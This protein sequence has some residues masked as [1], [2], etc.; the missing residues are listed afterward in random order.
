MPDPLYV[1]ARRVLLDALEALREHI[2]ALVLVGAQAVYVHAGEADLAVAPTTTDGDLA[3][4]PARLGPA[5]ILED[6]LARAGFEQEHNVVGIWHTSADVEGTPRVVQVDLL[7]PASLG[8]PGRRGARIPPHGKAVARKVVGLEGAL[9]D[10]DLHLITPLE[11]GDDR[12]IRMAVAGPAALLVAKVHKIG[13]RVDDRD[14]RSDK[15][16]LDVYRLLRAVPTDE[17]ARRFQLLREDPVSASVTEQALRRLPELFGGAR[18]PGVLMAVRAA[19][20]LEPGDTIA[21]S[22]TVLSD[23]LG[24]RL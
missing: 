19:G 15:D 17:L 1:A 3:I 4:D 18:R 12:K 9:V 14:R 6:A 22:L 2:D 21:A 8:G 16:A 13:D 11:P 7:V 5:P 20:P 10:R 23:D 24:R